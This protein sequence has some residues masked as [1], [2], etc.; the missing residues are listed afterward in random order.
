MGRLDNMVSTALS[1]TAALAE[2]I[3]DGIRTPVKQVAGIVN[4][5]KVGLDVLLHKAKGFGGYRPPDA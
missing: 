2:T 5:F 4:G 3:H 1:Q